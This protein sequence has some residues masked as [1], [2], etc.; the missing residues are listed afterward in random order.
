MPTLSYIVNQYV[1]QTYTQSLK[2]MKLTQTGTVYLIL[3]SF[4][5]ITKDQ[6]TGHTDINIRPIIQPT[7]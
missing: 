1:P 4:K 3:T 5:T 6:I 2:A 7:S